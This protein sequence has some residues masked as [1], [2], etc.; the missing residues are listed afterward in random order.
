VVISP[1]WTRLKQRVEEL[2]TPLRDWKLL[3]NYGIKT[4]CNEAF[5]VNGKKR[6]ELIAEDPRSAE[7]LKP[8]LRGRDIKRYA[9]QFAD[10]WMIATFPA[11]HIDIKQYPA[12]H[13]HLLG[14]GT[15]LDQSGEPGCRKKTSNQWF[16]VQDTIAYHE[17][18]SKEK[19][20]YA[21]IVYDS[22]F[23]YDAAG[24]A[25]EATSFI[26]TGERVKYLAALL[27]SRFLTEVFKRF[28]AGGDLRGN[29]FRYKKAF[30]EPLPVPQLDA[31]ASRPFEILVDCVQ[32]ARTHD[33]LRE[34]DQIEA[35]IDGLV[36]DLY[37][38]QEMRQ[39]NCFITERIRTVIQPFNQKDSDTFKNEYI[40]TLCDFFR[41]DKTVRHAIVHRKNV[42]PV[43]L[44]VGANA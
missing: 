38:E 25:P 12:V 34:A 20:I 10:L 24:F 43:N 33:M 21:E 16:E 8:I 32:H 22:A 6:D 41:N 27:N 17:E 42:Y 29:T 28:Y 39:A 18:F 2:G 13:N 40:Q 7:I 37:F 31:E 35:V 1:E 3:L 23:Y 15:R 19:L 14:F 9:V 44:I 26:M 30:L 4:G 11:L 5:I 36:Y